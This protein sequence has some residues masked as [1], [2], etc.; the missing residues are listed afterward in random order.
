[1][2]A[3]ALHDV[4]D[5]AVLRRW[6]VSAAA[7]LAAHAALIAIGMNWIRQPPEPGVTL[8]AIMVDM[9]PVSS[10][11][12][13]TPL[14][15]APDQVMDQADA[16]PP[17]PVKQQ[18]V[19][20]EQIAPTAP[21]ERPEV[22]APPEQK[23]EM[24]P[25]A[26]PAKPVPEA[27][28]TSVKPKVVRP[29]AKQPNELDACAAH[30]GATARRTS[31]PGRLRGQRRRNGLGGRVVQSARP[32]ASDALPP[33]PC[34]GQPPARRGQSFFHVKPQRAGSRRPACRIIGC[35]CARCSGHGNASPGFA[36]SGVSAGNY[37]GLGGLQ[38]S[39]EIYRAQIAAV[40]YS[41][42]APVSDET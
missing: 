16:S 36:V 42:T 24:T 20:E 28:P 11:P 13:S 40:D 4:S 25:A 33:V 18:E 14:E 21:Q 15:R 2:N 5:Q 22:V 8:P 19:V 31:G 27:K 12:Q 41:F 29:E 23:V 7:I 34:G 32:R 9:S 37:A 6:G 39:G 38:H 3:F 26:E 17:E 30:R 1:M 35:R 10:A